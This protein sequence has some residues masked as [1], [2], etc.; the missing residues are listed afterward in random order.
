M[1]YEL[2]ATCYSSRFTFQE[3]PTKDS[4]VRVSHTPVCLV[5]DAGVRRRT[6]QITLDK[7]ASVTGRANLSEQVEIVDYVPAERGTVLVVEALEEKSVYGELELK[8]GRMAR[9][10]KGDIIAGVLGERQ[11]LKGFVG[12]IPARI[13]RKSTRLNSSHANI[14]YA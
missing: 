8:G 11:A 10:I 6:M 7:I 14:S 4:V 12:S 5:C 3:P 2:R 1:Q 9:I 13:D